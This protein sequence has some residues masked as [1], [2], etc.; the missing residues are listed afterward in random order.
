MV[1]LCKR[2]RLFEAGRMQLAAFG[3]HLGQP[4][5]ARF[6]H[7]Q[8]GPEHHRQQAPVAGF[9]APALGGAY[10]LGHLCDCQVCF[11]SLTG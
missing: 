6:R 5:P 11:R 4:K 1:R 9:A 8:A 10:E 3:V 7:A 2:Q